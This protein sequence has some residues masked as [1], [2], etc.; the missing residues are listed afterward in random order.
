MPTYKNETGEATL[1]YANF[2]AFVNSLTWS[3]VT[4]P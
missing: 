2:P 4:E 3:G 1:T